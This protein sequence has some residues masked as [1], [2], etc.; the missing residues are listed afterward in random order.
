MKNKQ[1]S[2]S[3]I[4]CVLFILFSCKKPTTTSPGENVSFTLN[5]KIAYTGLEEIQVVNSS[6]G[7][8]S[9]EWYID[10]QLVSE[11]IIITKDKLL[12][13]AY[14][15]KHELKLVGVNSGG[16]IKMCID[17]FEYRDTINYNA[18]KFSNYTNS[19]I[20]ILTVDTATQGSLFGL[21]LRFPS[22][23]SLPLN[24]YP[25][26]TNC[27]VAHLWN[28][29][30]FK[31]YENKYFNPKSKRTNMGPLNRINIS[32][33]NSDI[34]NSYSLY[35]L[36]LFDRVFGRMGFSSKILDVKIDRKNQFILIKTTLLDITLRI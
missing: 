27:L 33:L 34:L 10:D 31:A 35:G 28:I 32:Y 22:N 11:N 21:D 13:R 14:N 5:Q 12:S 36:N 17:T 4:L 23:L 8:W 26:E 30:S 1:Y 9:F 3:V 29:D 16:I 6:V 20:K 19:F 2:K 24:H 25:P 18:V 15:V 7:T